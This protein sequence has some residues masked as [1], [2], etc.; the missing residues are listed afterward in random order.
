MNKYIL[1]L[2]TGFIL[3]FS[4]ACRQEKQSFNIY[5]SPTGNDNNDGSKNKPFATLERARNA[6]RE[7]KASTPDSLIKNINVYLG[8]GVYEFDQTF[9]LK[10]EDAGSRNSKIVYKAIE[11]GKAVF[12]GGTGIETN[13][14][15]SIKES[16][17][18][19]IFKEELRDSIFFIDLKEQGIADY[20]KMVQHGF[21]IAIKPAPMEL[22][23]ND[24]SMHLARW[25][26]DSMIH[27]LE[28][29]SG[30]S[31]PRSGDTGKEGGIFKYGPK[32]PSTWKENSNLWV[33]GYFNS[34][35][36][37]DNIKVKEID[38]VNNI[39]SLLQ[40]HM[41]GIASSL[42]ENHWAAHLR[43]FYF[44]NIPEELDEPGEYYLDRN[45]GRIYF[46][47]PTTESIKKVQASILEEPMISLIDAS[48]ITFDG[49]TFECS[50][51]MGIYM[52]GGERVNIKNCTFRNL[53]TVA[54]MNGQGVAGDPVPIHEFT[55]IP[56]SETIGNLKAH[57]YD[58][59]TWNR[60]G[61]EEHLIENCLIYQTGTGGI[62]L[63]GGDRLTLDPGRN[64]VKNCEI[65]HYNRINGAY[66]PAVHVDG[67]GNEVVDCY[68]H[69]APHQGVAIFGNEHLIQGTLF[70]NVCMEA[71][72]MGAVYMGRNPTERGNTVTECIFN[73]IG[74]SHEQSVSAIYLDDLISGMTITSNV[75]RKAGK[76]YFSAVYV[77]NGSDVPISYNLFIDT[78]SAYNLEAHFATEDIENWKSRIA[79]GGIY[80]T[81]LKAVN[82]KSDP[83]KTMYPNLAN[84]ENDNPAFPSRNP[85]HDNLVIRTDL[86]ESRTGVDKEGFVYENLVY[87]DIQ[88]PKD[89]EGF[90]VDTDIGRWLDMSDVGNVLKDVDLTL[91]DLLNAENEKLE[92]K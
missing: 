66:C 48:H 68:I 76:G 49:I 91:E 87:E 78:K 28:V 45:A 22:F 51:G 35:I 47:P 69:D 40:P 92:I 74:S 44:Y 83:W 15:K 72:D 5:L 9:R 31:V 60:K 14:V 55:G 13:S 34:P 46:Y 67:V 73:Q 70:E 82:Y 38:T 1:L 61:G 88:L 85:F 37:D 2:L 24:K 53:G 80:D 25:P 59:T 3:L 65:H 81:R 29:I 58:N 11:E 52:E 21:S 8:D 71:S 56:A 79:E 17:I 50:R 62:I 23:I 16:P 54:I 4:S 36:A 86:Y 12:S 77:N 33:Y 20:G 32:Q 18:E 64:V 41:Y 39:I 26:N 30:G 19:N 57:M 63:S 42:E 90:D 6:I 43:R 89:H 84:F 27:V 10:K 75:F 7:H